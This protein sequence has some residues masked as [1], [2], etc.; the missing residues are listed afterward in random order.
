MDKTEFT[1]I[2]SNIWSK[3]NFRLSLQFKDVVFME[4]I[5]DDPDLQKIRYAEITKDGKIMIQMSDEIYSRRWLDL[6]MKDGIYHIFFQYNCRGNKNKLTFGISNTGVCYGD[7]ISKSSNK[8][9]YCNV[10]CEGKN[11]EGS[12][13]RIVEKKPAF[14]NHGN[15]SIY[16]IIVDINNKQFWIKHNNSKAILVAEDFSP[17]VYA[18]VSLYY[19]NTS[20]TLKSVIHKRD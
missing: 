5:Y 2:C 14:I 13:C 4:S 17:P 11:V 6:E 7:A 19:V 18:L 8:C 1:V 16:E 3:L 12:L 20:V 10:E 15:G 9:L